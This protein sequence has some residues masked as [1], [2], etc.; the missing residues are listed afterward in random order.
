MAK[1]D[2]KGN[3][4]IEVEA[5]GALAN[6]SRDMIQMHSTSKDLGGGNYAAVTMMNLTAYIYQLSGTAIR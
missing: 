3:L 5:H 4:W 6:V 2:E 1:F